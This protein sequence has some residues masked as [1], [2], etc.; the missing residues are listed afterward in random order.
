MSLD[1]LKEICGSN[2]INVEGTRKQLI[3]RIIEN[4]K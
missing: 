2:N 1:K 4:S 3:A